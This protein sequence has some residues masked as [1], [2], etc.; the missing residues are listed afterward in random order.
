MAE[1]LR[2]VA[3][4]VD[5]GG[6]QDNTAVFDRLWGLLGE[7]RAKVDARL[8]TTPDASVAEF[9]ELDTESGQK[10]RFQA[11]SS[12]EVDWLVHSWIGQPEAG[13][14]NMHLTAWLGPQVDVPHLG[15]AWGTIPDVW[16]YC[17]LIPRSDL[18]TD[19]PS[20]DR[21]YEPWNERW[22]DVREQ[23]PELKVFTSRSLY[24]RQ[25]LSE[26][27]YVYT[28]PRS[29]GIIDL[30]RDLVHERVDAWLGWLDEA[31]P[32][33]A[34]RRAALAERDL[35]IRRNIAERD[36]ANVLGVR[37][38]GEETTARLVR[39]LWGGDRLNPRPS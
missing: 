18:W 36:P 28:S 16:F 8:P 3:D 39:S 7:V 24:V 13:F 33:P 19:L 31:E 37:F 2:H 5:E 20:L 30:M 32:V 12:D 27:A 38:F 1:Q 17:D 10:V 26:V 21:Y 34:D 35:A 15:L 23:H 11:S 9:N 25:G 14:S 29:D 4:L 22:L 6:A